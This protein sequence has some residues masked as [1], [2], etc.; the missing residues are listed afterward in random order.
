M[1]YAYCKRLV[2]DKKTTMCLVH[3]CEYYVETDDMKEYHKANRW[4]S[5]R[6]RD[7]GDP[8]EVFCKSEVMENW[9]NRIEQ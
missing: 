8:N 9:Q 6:R 3:Q 1:K 4:R 5:E 7:K 2:C